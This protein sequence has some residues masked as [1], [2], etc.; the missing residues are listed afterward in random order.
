MKAGLPKSGMTVVI[1][2]NRIVATGSSSVIRTIAIPKNALT[3]DGHRKFL[4]PAFWDM[5]VHLGTEDFDRNSYLP[6]FIANGVTGIRIMDGEPEYHQWRKEI[7]NGSLIGPRMFIASR[8]VGFSELSNI[9]EA[10]AREEV[11]RAKK[12]G[13]D[14][15]KVHDNVPRQSYFAL[16]DEAKGLNLPVEGHVPTSIS[17][18]EASAAGQK[19][20][21]HST[22]LDEAKSDESKAKALSALFKMNRTWLCP[23][24]IMRNNYATLDNLAL[25]HD[26][27]LKYVKPSW[28]K[29]W[30]GMT[31][32]AADMT[33]AEWSK[34][35][36]M[37]RKEKFLVAS[38]Q[39]R[40]V[41]ILAGTDDANPYAMVGFG[42]HDELAMLVDAG[43]TPIQ[44]LQAATLNPAKFFDKLDSLGTIEKGKLA[45]LVLLDANPLTD[46][47]NTKRISA[48]VVNGRYFPPAALQKILADVESA[49]K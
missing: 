4:L 27:R 46:I 41:G 15:V 29:R 10:R 3:I 49:A 42:L 33:T 1:H 43:L 26:P 22:G 32:A 2:R 18:A 12:E 20:I 16:I 47:R 17:A 19:S 21:E 13:A 9:S 45:D 5:H 14:F 24:L 28:R 44:A 8:V 31:K 7:E 11:K 30:L 35:K 39:Q 48:V 25:A 38:M 23:T 34:R 37:I 36:E 6:L 40:G